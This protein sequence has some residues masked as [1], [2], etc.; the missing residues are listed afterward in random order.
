MLGLQSAGEGTEGDVPD[1]DIQKEL[2]LL[3]RHLLSSY[4]DMVEATKEKPEEAVII[5]QL[6]EAL[7]TLQTEI[8]A[9]QASLFSRAM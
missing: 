9:A 8:D 1:I 5:K 7:Q 3:V 6:G 4:N 2:G